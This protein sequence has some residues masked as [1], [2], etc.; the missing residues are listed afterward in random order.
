MSRVKRI[1]NK[2]MLDAL[3]ACKGIITTAA[4]SLKINRKTIQRRLL[5][6]EDLRKSYDEI[7]EANIDR[8]ESRLFDLIEKGDRRAI[9]YYL[10]R[11]ARHRGYGKVVENHNVNMEPVQIYLPDNQR[12]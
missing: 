8:A 1:T 12:Q 10:D 3:E 5:D 2:Q 7:K 6:N 11:V 4:A 9:T